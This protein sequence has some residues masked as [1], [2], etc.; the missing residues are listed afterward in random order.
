[1]GQGQE[2]Q[3]SRHQQQRQGA[4]Q[5]DADGREQPHVLDA[6]NRVDRQGQKTEHR[7]QGGQ[8]DRRTGQAQG[9]EHHLARAAVGAGQLVILGHHVER[10]GG[11]EHQQQRRQGH[12]AQAQPVAAQHD[13]A[14][15][16]GQADDHGQHRQHY[17]PRG[18]KAEGQDDHDEYQGQGHEAGQIL[19]HAP[20]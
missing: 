3:A 19:L 4:G 7:G 5:T 2:D 15:R 17:P 6:D 12:A 14:Q 8:A 16:P 13:D 9:L 1:M 10:V 20:C 11:A 18:A